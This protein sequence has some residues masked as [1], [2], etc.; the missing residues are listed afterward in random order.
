M[1]HWRDWEA[2]AAH[3]WRFKTKRSRVEYLMVTRRRWSSLTTNHARR[4]VE[5]EDLALGDSKPKLSRT[6]STHPRTGEWITSSCSLRTSVCF[7][8]T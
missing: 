7:S 1:A 2:K 4:S 6:L 3:P 8:A 5:S